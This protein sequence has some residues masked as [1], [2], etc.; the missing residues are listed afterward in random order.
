M[1]I[2]KGFVTEALTIWMGRHRG[3]ALNSQ[4]VWVEVLWVLDRV[5]AKMGGQ[6]ALFDWIIG[7]CQESH[8]REDWEIDFKYKAD[9]FSLYFTWNTETLQASKQGSEQF[10]AKVSFFFFN[11]I[12]LFLT[13]LGL[14]SSW[15]FL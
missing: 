2:I 12:Y 1:I 15:A 13:V 8:G 14:H 11:F 7:Y 5:K 6:V 4:E 10:K 9:K 3:G